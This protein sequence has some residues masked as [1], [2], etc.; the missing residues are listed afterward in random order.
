MLVMKLRI[1]IHRVC[2]SALSLLSCAKLIKFNF[3]VSWQAG[4]Y[5]NV[6]KQRD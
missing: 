1:Y 3:S 6:L 4:I 2:G 5:Q